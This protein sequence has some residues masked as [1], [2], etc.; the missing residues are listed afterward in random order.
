[1]DVGAQPVETYPV[2]AVV[3]QVGR[4]AVLYDRHAA[5][6]AIAPHHF[7]PAWWRERRSELGSASGR[8]TVM[9]VR[10]LDG[11]ST[12]VLR[13][14]LRGGWMARLSRDRYL[15]TGIE[16]TRAWRE[17]RLTHHLR[18]LGLPVPTPV[19]AHVARGLA[20][21]SADLLT[22]RIDNARTLADVLRERAIPA[23]AWRQL[24][25]TLRRFHDVGVHHDD[26]NVSNILVQPDGSFHVIDFDKAAL[27]APGAWREQNLA[28][29]LRSLEKHRALHETFAFS[30]ANWNALR[31]GYAG[32]AR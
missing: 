12:W 3:A 23:D 9:F 32:P 27:V 16:R 28:R 1:M 29:F 2:N 14:Y 4:S 22:Q 31:A 11:A 7:D 25:A 10:A 17:W 30:E 6:G 15:W 26:I 5:G 18:S 20:T 21:Y 13:H 19:A 8:G 24:G